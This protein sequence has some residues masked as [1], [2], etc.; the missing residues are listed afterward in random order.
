MTK[1]EQIKILVKEQKD[2]QKQIEDV[3]R[4]LFNLGRQRERITQKI[5]WL[6]HLIREGG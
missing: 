1:E 5:N 6:S 2:V 3:Q 4:H